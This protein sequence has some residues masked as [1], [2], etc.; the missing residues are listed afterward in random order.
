MGLFDFVKGIGKKILPRQ[1][2]NRLHWRR[3]QNRLHRKWPIN[4]WDILNL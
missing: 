1:S 3:Q 2:N 4:Y